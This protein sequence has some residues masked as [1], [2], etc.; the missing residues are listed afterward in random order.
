MTPKV[1]DYL[2][3]ARA[4][5]AVASTW[6]AFAGAATFGLLAI[7]AS[8]TDVWITSI[9]AVATI[10]LVVIAANEIY[11]EI[12]IYRM[13]LFGATKADASFVG[14]LG[15]RESV[16]LEAKQVL[17]SKLLWAGAQAVVLCLTGL[18][19]VLLAIWLKWRWL[20]LVPAG[21]AIG[22]A[23]TIT[24][25]VSTK[26]IKMGIDGTAAEDALALL[27]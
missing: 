16:R 8:T 14:A 5:R 25:N 7:V 12:T 22:L 19:L 4:S 18:I 6:L 26:G 1:T 27:P 15:L 21:I 13:S 3:A 20:G 24:W 11:R 17:N 2:D 9:G 23:L 10:S